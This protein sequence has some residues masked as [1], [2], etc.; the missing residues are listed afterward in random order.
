MGTP[1]SPATRAPWLAR[2]MSCTVNGGTALLGPRL[3][4][5]SSRN[6]AVVERE[7]VGADD[8]IGLVPLPGND[9]CVAGLGPAERRPDRG[10]A[11]G[12]GRVAAPRPP[13]PPQ[14]RPDPVAS[15]LPPLPTATSGVYPPPAPQ[16]A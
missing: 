16:H 13:R 8:L 7:H 10:R 2:T 12:R 1:R 14:P 11:V 4:Q 5:D 3:G 9:H 15:R 6:V